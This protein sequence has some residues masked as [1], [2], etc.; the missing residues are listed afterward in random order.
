MGNISEHNKKATSRPTI[1]VETKRDENLVFVSNGLFEKKQELGAV[2][3]I[4][5]AGKF[6]QSF[7]AEL[8][9][10]RKLLDCEPSTILD[11]AMVVAKVNLEL[12]LDQCYLIPR[13]IK[14]VLTCCPQFGYKGKLRLAYNGGILIG[15]SMAFIYKEEF[16][17]KKVVDGVHII[18]H[19]SFMPEKRI[20]GIYERPIGIHG[21]ANL[22]NGGKETLVLW[23]KPDIDEIKMLSSAYNNK[24][25]PSKWE[26][27]EIQKWN[28]SS[29]VT[30]EMKMWKKS[31]IIRLLDFIPLGVLAVNRTIP[32]LPVGEPIQ[33]QDP[34]A[35]VNLAN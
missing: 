11:A 29:W 32:Q 6:T 7:I 27:W 28:N 35:F 23:D 2:L 17:E 18:N 3:Q 16:F 8:N 31:L 33:A 30:N 21:V 20:G 26:T 25:E 15:T 13:K 14:G 1:T 5:T 24:V 10:N 22:I 9:G 34:K 19:T 12:E 4:M